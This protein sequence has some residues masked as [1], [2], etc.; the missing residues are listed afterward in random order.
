M[1]LGIRRMDQGVET[2]REQRVECTGRHGLIRADPK[3]T[4]SHGTDLVAALHTDLGK[5]STEAFRTE[6]DFTVREID[7]IL[8]HLDSWLRPEPVPLPA[9]LGE[10]SAWTLSPT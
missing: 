1:Q 4:P 8:D 10:A 2:E 3:D 6:I 5:S 9:Y 7:H